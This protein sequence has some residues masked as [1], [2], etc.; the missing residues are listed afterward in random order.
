MRDRFGSAFQLQLNFLLS[1][2]TCSED[3]VIRAW[4]L[5]CKYDMY[6]QT[7]LIHYSLP[8]FTEGPDRELQFTSSDEPAIRRI[9]RLLLKLKQSS[10]AR[11][12]ASVRSLQ[13]I[14]DWL[15]KGPAM[16]VPCDAYNMAWVGAD[17]SVQMCYAAFPLGN[18]HRTRLKEMLFTPS[19][20][21]AARGAFRLECP[22]CHCEGSTRIEKHLPSRLRYPG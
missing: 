16:R 20:K 8:Y 21:A 4:E 22:N 12:A 5:A 15:L 6:F 18:L 13:S 2:R 3:A 14:P 11:M 9:C 7:D 10:P 1:R 17:G 19:H